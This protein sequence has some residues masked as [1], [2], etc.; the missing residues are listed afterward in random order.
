MRPWKFLTTTLA[1]LIDDVGRMT[2]N[3]IQFFGSDEWGERRWLVLRFPAAQELPDR[4]A[5]DPTGTTV[6]EATIATC[7][8]PLRREG[9]HSRAMLRGRFRYVRSESTRDRW[10]AFVRRFLH[11]SP[12]S[13]Y[14][15]VRVLSG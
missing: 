3:S 11:A 6:Y 10:D 8:I 1:V 4:L 2:D 15:Y 12:R 13:P 14:A 7:R 5:P 9:P